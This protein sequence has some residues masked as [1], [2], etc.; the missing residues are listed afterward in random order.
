MPGRS[1]LRYTRR[2]HAPARGIVIRQAAYHPELAEKSAADK[3]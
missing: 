2:G 3:K 1:L